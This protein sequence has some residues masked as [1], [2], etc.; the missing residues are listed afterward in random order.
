MMAILHYCRHST[1]TRD[2]YTGI[3]TFT[4]KTEHAENGDKHAVENYELWLIQRWSIWFNP[5]K[6]KKE[7]IKKK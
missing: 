7:N 2:I 3:C 4:K 1:I 6:N 5:N